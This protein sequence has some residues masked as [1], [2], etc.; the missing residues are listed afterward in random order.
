MEKQE[1][2]NKKLYKCSICQSEFESLRNLNKHITENHI[3]S[4]GENLNAIKTQEANTSFKCYK[5]DQ[6]YTKM[7][8]LTKKFLDHKNSPHPYDCGSCD[9][10]FTTKEFRISHRVQVHR[11]VIRKKTIQKCGDCGK[12]YGKVIFS[13]WARKFKKVPGQKDS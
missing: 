8:N 11:I 4:T 12:Q 13:Q 1:K 2:S 6:V 7:E 5:C 9:K 10:R 3:S